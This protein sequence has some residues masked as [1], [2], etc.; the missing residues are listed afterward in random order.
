VRNEKELQELNL[1]P[2][3][4]KTQIT[5]TDARNQNNQQQGSAAQQQQQQQQR[6]QPN[7]TQNSFGRPR[8]KR[9]PAEPIEVNIIWA[10]RP[11]SPRRPILLILKGHLI[12]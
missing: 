11:D 9:E 4:S 7:A 2:R 10:C 5:Q 1:F 6:Q 8:P 12:N 3:E